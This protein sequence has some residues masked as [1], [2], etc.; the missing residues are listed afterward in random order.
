MLL[1]FRKC[2]PAH[3]RGSSC[4]KSEST[5]GTRLEKRCVCRSAGGSGPDKGFEAEGLGPSFLQHTQRCDVGRR[6]RGMSCPA[7]LGW[8]GSEHGAQERSGVLGDPGGGLIVRCSNLPQERPH[9]PLVKR[10]AACQHD[11]QAHPCVRTSR[12]TAADVRSGCYHITMLQR[13][14]ADWYI[15]QLPGGCLPSTEPL[16]WASN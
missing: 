9:R 1:N 2:G 3:R 8:I 6:L 4:K 12:V 16:P 15:S 5:L 10:Q 11:V 13:S 7:P 14:D